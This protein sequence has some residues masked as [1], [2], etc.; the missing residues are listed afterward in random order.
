MEAKV[1][2]RLFQVAFGW[3]CAGMLCSG[4]SLAQGPGLENADPALQGK[5]LEW[6]NEALNLS[7]KYPAD[8]V[9]RDP[10]E[11]WKDEHL[12]VYGIPGGQVRQLAVTTSCLKP[13]LS[14]ELPTSGG[15]AIKTEKKNPDG[16]STFTIRPALL[17]TILLAEVDFDCL[18]PELLGK[19]IDPLTQ[20]LSLLPKVPGMHSVIPPTMYLLDKQK[21]YMAGAQGLP[22]FEVDPDVPMDPLLTFTLGFATNWDSHLLVWY[23]SA[24]NTNTMNRM[25]KSLVKFGSQAPRVLYP[26]PVRYS[27][28]R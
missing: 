4:L 17:G 24:N 19:T 7:F 25:T 23:L 15:L 6:T 9:R 26:L 14:L 28:G 13:M 27:P 18:K 11:A 21:I 10:N 3:I 1:S 12:M 16:S 20:M 5:Q 2:P 22:K 8:L